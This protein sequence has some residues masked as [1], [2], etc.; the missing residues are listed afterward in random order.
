MEE[1]EKKQDME[2]LREELNHWLAEEESDDDWKW[3]KRGGR[4]LSSFLSTRTEK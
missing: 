2:R 4:H 3:L 1:M